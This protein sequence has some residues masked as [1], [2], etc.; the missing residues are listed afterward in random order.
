M[1]TRIIVGLLFSAAGTLFLP[2]APIATSVG[3]EPDRGPEV[4]R[5][6]RT[7]ITPECQRSI[8][9]GMNFLFK[10]M[11]VD[12]F[13][14]TDIGRP[15]DLGC[16]AMVGLALLSQGN[17]PTAGPNRAELQK[18]LN[19]VLDMVDRLPED[20]FEGRTPTLVQRKIGRNADLFLSTLFLS[21]ILGE[22]SYAEKDVRGALETLVTVIC[23][24]QGK[25]GTWGSE[26]WAPVLGT[27]LGWECL[28]ASSSAGLKVDA[29]AKLAGDALLAGLKQKSA[30]EQGWMHDFYKNAS[31]I[32]VLYSLNYRHDPVFEEC[33]QRI[34]NT[35]KQDDRPFVQAG[36][37][38]FL[39][40]FLV[41]ECMLQERDESW[42]AWY[43]TVRDKLIRIQNGDG[44]W[45][46]HHCITARTFCTAAALLTLQASNLYMPISNL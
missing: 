15:P 16:T 3:F 9:R 19:A 27:V 46:G 25:D 42:Q 10:A 21:Q 6:V 37:E 4:P 23:R 28:R 20:D 36:G 7:K 14:G 29:S 12:G 41:T 45:S 30:T 33:V 32:R 11:R 5:A 34:L 40:F 26:S 44:S 24:E 8:D 17:T 38:E 43:P 39:A 2:H 22:A 35:A 18:V 31:S 1:R 13:V